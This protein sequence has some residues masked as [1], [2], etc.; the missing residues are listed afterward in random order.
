MSDLLLS[1]DHF[2]LNASTYNSSSRDEPA[3][4]HIQDTT[5]ILTRSD[6]WLVHITRFAV[7]AMKSLVFIEKDETAYWSINVVSNMGK[8]TDT[9]NFQLDR[10]YATVQ[11]LLSEM[12]MP[13]RF[14][15]LQQGHFPAG[16]QTGEFVEMY[17]F[18]IDP[19]GRIKLRS[20]PDTTDPQAG[21]HITYQASESMNRLLGFV[22]VTPYVRWT[23]NGAHRFCRALEMLEEKMPAIATPRNLYNGS[24]A[25]A[26]HKVLVPLLNGV[27][28]FFRNNNGN[29]AAEADANNALALTS[30]IPRWKGKTVT[31]LNAPDEAMLRS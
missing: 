28:I 3:I 19:A 23:P 24:Y 21:W 11:D 7:D 1:K 15:Q 26:I 27:Q 20:Q 9:F 5:D 31:H 13:G 22:E 10:D 2:Y 6:G 12:N 16:N 17:R 18:E 14:K 30:A 8:P 25:L 29:E 4:V